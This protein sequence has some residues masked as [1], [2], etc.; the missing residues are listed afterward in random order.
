MKELAGEGHRHIVDLLA[1]RV[2]AVAEGDVDV[3]R[4]VILQGA[5][6]TGKSRV[7]R[8]LYRV[9]RIELDGGRYWPELQ[10]SGGGDSRSPIRYLAAKAPALTSRGSSGRPRHCRASHGGNCTASA[11]R[12]DKLSTSSLRPARKSRRISCLSPCLGIAPRLS[13]RKWLP[14]RG[15]SLT[16]LGRRC[17]KAA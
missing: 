13:K 11:C 7:V 10:E 16:G 1:A 15:Y 6:G 12:P 17:A 14:R 4:A 3:P 5:S 2:R 9:L 8:E